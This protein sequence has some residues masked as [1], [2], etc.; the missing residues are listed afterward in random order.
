[1]ELD[2]GVDVIKK[3]AWLKAQGAKYLINALHKLEVDYQVF[4]LTS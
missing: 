3:G 2:D 4:Y 1:M